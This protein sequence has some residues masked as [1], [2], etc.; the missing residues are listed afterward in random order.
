[1]VINDSLKPLI[2]CR[3]NVPL[4]NL[5]IME[6][7]EVWSFDEVKKRLSTEG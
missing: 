4:I 3:M 1:M 7:M 6:L 2:K 5:N